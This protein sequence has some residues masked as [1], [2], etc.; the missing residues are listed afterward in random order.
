MEGSWGEGATRGRG[1]ATAWS[2][3]RSSPPR[4]QRR[5]TLETISSGEIIYEG[6]LSVTSQCQHV[7]SRSD[8]TAG[9]RV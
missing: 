5:G 3:T 4:R 8:W 9:H 1:S 6:N 2:R 7:M